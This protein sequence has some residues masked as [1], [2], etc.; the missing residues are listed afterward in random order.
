MKAIKIENIGDVAIIDEFRDI[1]LSSSG[2]EICHTSSKPREIL[3]KLK[4]DY[5]VILQGDYLHAQY[6]LFYVQRFENE[7]AD[8][9]NPVESKR[10][11]LHRL[12]YIAHQSTF[13]MFDNITERYDFHEWVHEWAAEDMQEHYYLIPARRYNRIMTDI[14][15][16]EDGIS[17]DGLHSKI[18]IKP[19]VYVPFDKSVPEMLAQ[20]SDLIKD[21]SVLDVGTGTGIIA[22]LSAQMG[23][24]AVSACDINPNAVECAKNNVLISGFENVVSEIVYS[25]LFGNIKDT[26][27]IITFNAPWVQ[28]K[29][30]N[31]YEL[32][33]Y[34]EN[35]ALV[36][37]FM[38]EAPEY[39]NPDGTIL[40]QYSDISQKNGDGAIDNLNNILEQNGL[41]IAESTSILRKNRMFGMMER[42]L[43]FALKKQSVQINARPVP[44]AKV[45]A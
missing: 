36:N 8:K 35:Y 13:P 3:E 21:K 11:R 16:A 24:R 6:I 14:K 44:S 38:E 26:Y 28:G 42:V 12:N 15:R 20:F 18:Y 37:R 34:D 39:L 7:L 19:H 41:Y 45:S 30:Q 22:I 10:T 23:A 27:D 25:D 9:S 1:Y 29:A 40:L 43:L 17:I 33:I 4:N 32:A 31:L 5:V 2:I